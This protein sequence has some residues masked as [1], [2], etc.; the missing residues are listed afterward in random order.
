MEV[1]LRIAYYYYMASEDPFLCVITPIFDGAVEALELLIG[2]LK[3]QTMQDFIHIMISA[4]P[5]NKSCNL[6]KSFND[7]RF[8]Y[9]EYTELKTKGAEELIASLGERRTHCFKKYKAHRYVCLDADLKIKSD[10]YF[11]RLQQCHHDADI[12]ITKV[13]V[14]PP[15][16]NGPPTVFPRYPLAKGRLD[17]SNFSFSRRLATHP[18]CIYPTD[19]GLCGGRDGDWRFFET[20]T[21]FASR[22]GD[23]NYKILPIV[24][25]VYNGNSTYTSVSNSDN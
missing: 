9:E 20:L 3:K 24:S 22:V 25:A 1:K 15:K 6:I 14:W 5:S 17:L 12:L 21:L 11:L 10:D 8:I 7:P 23:E 19:M 13:W 18:G 16:R 2:A 4:G